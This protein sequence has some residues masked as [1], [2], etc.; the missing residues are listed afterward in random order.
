MRK[1]YKNFINEN[2]VNEL[3]SDK[4]LFS[5]NN[6]N[7]KYNNVISKIL[8]TIQDD[9]NFVIKKESYYRLEKLGKGHGWHKDTGD[10]DQMTWC[11][12]GVSLLLTDD[13][14]GGDTWYADNENLENA[15]KIERQK[16]DLIVH[17]SNEWHKVDAHKGN[18]IVLLMFI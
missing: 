6:I 10:T 4:S 17:D 13:F 16:Y 14:T 2:E 9:F 18:R 3:L 12:I 7:L 11:Q 15:I 1:L 8:H 5:F